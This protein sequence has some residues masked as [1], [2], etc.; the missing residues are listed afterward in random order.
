MFFVCFRSILQ[1]SVRVRTLSRFCKWWCQWANRWKC[2]KFSCKK[3][4]FTPTPICMIDWMRKNIS[5]T[6]RQFVWFRVYR[7]TTFAQTESPTSLC[8]R[9]FSWWQH[10]L[11]ISML[12]RLKISKSIC[13]WWKE[14]KNERLFVV[15]Y[16]ST[17]SKIFS[18]RDIF[19]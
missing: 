16:G 2:D 9:C 6:F 5:N 8:R 4:R 14:W 18:R 7:S 1:R 11:I 13:V 19:S 17:K 3:Q 15:V 12:E 10:I